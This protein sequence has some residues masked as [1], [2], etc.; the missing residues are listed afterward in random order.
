MMDL[1]DNMDRHGRARPFLSPRWGFEEERSDLFRGF[2]S[3][4]KRCNDPSGLKRAGTNSTY[5]NRG[6]CA[7]SGK[8]YLFTTKL[9]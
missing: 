6:G 5:H 8:K 4:A 2:T 3:P 9:I 1:M 7:T